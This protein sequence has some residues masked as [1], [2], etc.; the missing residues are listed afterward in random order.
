MLPELAPYA[1]D[2]ATSVYMANRKREVI[3][4]RRGRMVDVQDGGL[5][6]TTMTR[7]VH[8]PFRDFFRRGVCR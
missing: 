3:A 6:G 8:A 1:L 7:V 4:A 5:A 2:L